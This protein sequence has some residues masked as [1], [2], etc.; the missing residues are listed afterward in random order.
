MGE[1]ISF[2]QVWELK[3]ELKKNPELNDDLIWEQI[4]HMSYFLVNQKHTM[5]CKQCSSIPEQ[6]IPTSLQHCQYGL[7]PE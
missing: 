7:I 1:V 2:L 5:H 4:I 6:M 3:T